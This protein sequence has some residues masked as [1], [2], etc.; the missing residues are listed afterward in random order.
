MSDLITRQAAYDTLTKYYHHH[1]DVQHAALR[2]ALS[3]VPDANLAKR[4]PSDLPTDCIS[5]QA[6]IDAVAEGLKYIFVKYRDVAEKMLN[7]V[8]SA[9]PDFDITVKID[10]AY[11]D[12]YEAGY[13]QGRHDWGDLDE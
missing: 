4:L 2:E 11:D 9:Q 7:K 5:R 13:L 3:R 1:T 6:A 10:K 8:P 12:G